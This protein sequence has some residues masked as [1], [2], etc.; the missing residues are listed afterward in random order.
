MKIIWLT[1]R[2]DGGGRIWQ[3]RSIALA[4][5]LALAEGAGCSKPGTGSWVKGR[6]SERAEGTG[7]ALFCDP[8][9]EGALFGDMLRNSGGPNAFSRSTTVYLHE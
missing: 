8:T 1:G 5:A 3:R 9:R 6:G 2:T 7:E 4:L